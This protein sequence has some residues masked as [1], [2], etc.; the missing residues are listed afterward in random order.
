MT[1]PTSS[2]CHIHV[3]SLHDALI[4]QSFLD[5]QSHRPLAKSEIHWRSSLTTPAGGRP[6]RRKEPRWDEKKKEFCRPKKL[7]GGGQH[8]HCPTGFQYKGQSS[9]PSFVLFFFLLHVDNTSVC[10]PLPWTLSLLSRAGLLQLPSNLPFANLHSRRIISI[11]IDPSLG[12][13]KEPQNPPWL[14][15]A[16]PRHPRVNTCSSGPLEPSARMAAKHPFG[17]LAV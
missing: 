14:M 5:P 2:D 3:K 10:P 15:N 13:P 11:V 6:A 9:P 1:S 4:F 17:S 7:L 16:Y 12:S 8:N